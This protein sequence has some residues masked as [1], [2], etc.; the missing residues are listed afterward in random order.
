MRSKQPI[1]GLVALGSAIGAGLTYFFDPAS[2]RGRRA[3]TADR[4]AGVVRTGWRKSARGARIA[5]LQTAGA[6]RGVVH[7]EPEKELD[8]VTLARKVETEVFRAAEVPKGSIN[9]NAE[10]GAVYLR[11]E[12][13]HPEMVT[14]LEEAA[15]KIKGVREVHNLLHLPGTPAPPK[16]EEPSR[17]SVEA[18]TSEGPEGR[19]PG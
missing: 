3:R 15:R 4:A 8:D 9:V 12:V 6:V 1:A 16:E 10:D 2:G 17:E 11:G 19:L 5:G 18:D 13:K 14:E 7:R